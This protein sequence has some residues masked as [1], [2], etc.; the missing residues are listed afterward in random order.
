MLLGFLHDS[1]VGI[2]ASYCTEEPVLFHNPFDLLVIEDNL[3]A[4]Q[5][6]AD[7]PPAKLALAFFEYLPYEQ[8]VIVVFFRLIDILQPSVVSA[9]RNFGNTA[10]ESDIP[11]QRLDDSIL[12][13]GS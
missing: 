5:P 7:L 8:I 6:H 2:L 11:F 10:Q 1:L 13:V 4:F 9:L 12:L 3:P